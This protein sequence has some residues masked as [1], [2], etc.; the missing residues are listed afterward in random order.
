[1]AATLLTLV[2][3]DRE[4]RVCVDGVLERGNWMLNFMYIFIG[5]SQMVMS[6]VKSYNILRCPISTILFV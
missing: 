1:M 3:V 4:V 2:M 5:C 6:F